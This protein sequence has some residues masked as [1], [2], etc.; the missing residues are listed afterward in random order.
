[1]TD[2]KQLDYLIGMLYETV[3]NPT[4]WSEALGL[5][6]SYTDCTV[7]HMVVIDKRFNHPVFSAYGGDVMTQE[8]ESDYIN[9]YMSIDPRMT[10]N[11]MH[12]AAVHEWR[13]CHNYLGNQVINRSEFYQDYLI[14]SGGRYSM[15]AYVDDS[16]DQH[17]LIG[18]LRIV[19][20]PPFGDEEQMAAQRFSGHLQRALRL[21]R[22]TQNLQTKADLG[23][24]AIDALALSMLIVDGKGAIL[25]LNVGAE[26]LLNSRNSGLVCKDN[27]LL[28]ADYVCKNRLATLIAQAT[29]YPAVGGAMFLGGGQNRQ[30]LVT[31][32]PAASPFAQDWQTPLALVLVIEAGKNLSSLQLLGALYNL[33]PAELRVASAL[34][35]GKS[36]EEYA[37]EAGVSMNTVRSQLKNLFQKTGARRQ[38]ELVS[39]LGRVPPLQ[40]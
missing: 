5:C 35:A 12:N 24:R 39:M 25:H 20:Q 38:S 33:S 19:G 22:H 14:P 6:A 17:T 9:H 23:A 30:L 31:P 8:N 3:L 40:S 18:L 21:Q 36:P 15:G 2:D 29:G 27:H 13:C 1:M 37:Q 34:L 28:A 11:M 4:L 7:A 10:S 32:L 16:M 26:R